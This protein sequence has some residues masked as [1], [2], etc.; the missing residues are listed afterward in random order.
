MKSRFLIKTILGLLITTSVFFTACS[1]DENDPTPLPGQ[2]G[3][4]VVNEGAFN[5]GDASIS[6]F[7]KKTKTITN[8]V[9]LNN[10]GRPLGDQAQSMSIFNGKGYIVVQNSAKIEIIDPDDI[11]SIGSIGADQGIISPRY[12]LGY[13]ESKGYVSDW[14][15]DGITG[16]VKVL[17]LNTLEIT[18]S[19]S[20]GAG[21]NEMVLIGDKLYVANSGGY[22]S[23]NTVAIIDTQTDELI[24][25]IILGDN[26][27]N[28][29]VDRDRNVWVSGKGKIAY[30]SDWSIDQN[31]STP[32]FLAKVN[33]SD[34]VALKLE[35]SQVASG[36][37]KLVINNAGDKLYYNYAG[38]VY[39]LPITA[40]ALP[41][42]TFINRSFY[43]LA[44]D[45]S[46][47]DI[48]GGEAP[49]FSSAGTIYRYSSAGELIDEYKA[50]IA[51]NGFAFK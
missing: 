47:N 35:V 50:G 3:F 41:T 29:V 1:D 8:D 37:D 14:G 11:S 27:A 46:T 6:F 48:I 33:I 10:T 44:V 43:G 39:E 34:Q 9:F 19:I 16:T 49:N 38:G 7:D 22:G 25:K 4:F 24:K 32:G 31:N 26:P 40:N 45:P 51:P 28:L 23:D 2:E 30:N 18:K 13:S 21:A 5:N 36:P 20:T 42:E 17:D 15:S 12:F